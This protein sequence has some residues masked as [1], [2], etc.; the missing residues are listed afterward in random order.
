[1]LHASQRLRMQPRRKDL[2]PLLRRY[3]PLYVMMLPLH[4][5]LH[6]LSLSAHFGES[7]RV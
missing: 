5:L 7:H 1:M 2:W 3:L 6:H 4:R